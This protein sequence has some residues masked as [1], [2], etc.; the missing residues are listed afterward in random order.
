M[1]EKETSYADKMAYKDAELFFNKGYNV[2]EWKIRTAESENENKFY[3]EH[4]TKGYVA[5]Y[6]SKYPKEEG[7]SSKRFG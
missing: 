5:G 4:H 6:L 2:Q 3:Y 7:Q 1:A